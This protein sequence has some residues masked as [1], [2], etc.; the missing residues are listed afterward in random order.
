MGW[1]CYFENFMSNFVTSREN[2]RVVFTYIKAAQTISEAVTT[3][4]A[5]SLFI[6]PLTVVVFL[7]F[8]FSS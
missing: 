3:E 4:V 8:P 7:F 6:L 2:N 5:H 1:S